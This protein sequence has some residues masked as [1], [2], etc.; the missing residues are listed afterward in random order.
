MNSVCR[1]WLGDTGKPVRACVECKMV[2]NVYLIEVQA[3]PY[4]MRLS[5]RS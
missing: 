2:S 4:Q 1:Q 5:A 3:F